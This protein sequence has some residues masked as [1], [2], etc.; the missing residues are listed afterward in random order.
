[1]T[2]TEKQVQAGQAVYSRSMLAIYDWLV[3]RFSNRLIWKC[4]SRQILAL[5]DRHV[6][7]NHL[8]VGVGTG[9][10]LD[11]CRFPN[12]RPRLV[13]MDLNPNCL[14]AAAR[15]VA[16]YRPEIYRANVLDPIGFEGPRFDSIS[17][18]YLLHCLPGTIKTKGAVF[19]HLVPFLNQGGVLFG[20]TL[21]SAGVQRSPA[22]KRLMAFYNSKGIFTNDQDDLQ[23][24]S[25]M[26][27]DQFTAVTVQ[28]VGCAALFS[29]RR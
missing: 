11:R 26:L 19:R 1:M 18:T 17:M 9:Y 10:F 5:Y 25:A 24:L 14:D 20:A 23:G 2:M 22:A 6:T 8:D 15:R 3:L 16:R 29:A 27:S 21:L 13:L 7:A 4:P 12:E 28:V